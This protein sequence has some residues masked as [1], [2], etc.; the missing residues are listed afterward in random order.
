MPKATVVTLPDPSRGLMMPNMPPVTQKKAAKLQ[1]VIWSGYGYR[2]WDV[3]VSLVDRKNLS[4]N[5]LAF[6]LGRVAIMGEMA[7]FGLAFFAAVAELSKERALAVG[8]WA[9]AG[10]VSG[11]HYAE[12]GV[13]I[14]SMLAYWR[15][16][17]K[18]TRMHHKLLAVPLL[19]FAT[20]S[21]GG[22]VL[23]LCREATL[24]NAMT[25][26]FDAA[27]CMVLAYIFMY[28]APLLA[29]SR[30]G[31]RQASSENWMCIAVLLALAVAGIGSLTIYGFNIRN[32]AGS[33]LIMILALSGGAGLGAAVGVAIG[34]V[35]GLTEG[36]APQAITFYALSG[37]LAG[38]FRPLGKY[39]VILGYMLGSVITALYFGQ[40]REVTVVL[41]E[42][43]FAAAVFL[44]L[45]A[46]RLTVWSSSMMQVGADNIQRENEV[47]GK[48]NNIKDMFSDLANTFADIS[49]GAEERIREEELTRVLS[50]VGKKVCEECT[51]RNGCWENDFYQTSQGL[52]EMLELAEIAKLTTGNMPRHFRENCVKRADLVN[53][54]NLVV[55]RNHN[56]TYW[57]KKIVG[58]RQT[59][60]EQMQATANI[61]D[62]LAHEITKEPCSDKEM[63]FSIKEKAALLNCRLDSVRV[64]GTQGAA[65]VDICKQA[66]NGTRECTNTILPMVAN[67]MHEKL[68]L[69]AECGGGLK[70]KKCK[71]TLQT[72]NRFGVQTGMASSPKESHGVCGDTCAVVRL[73]K[74]KVALLLSDGMGSG[75]AAAAE[76]SMAVR[77]IEKLLSAGFDVDVAVKTINSM[78]LL[79]APDENFATVD[80]AIIDTYSGEVEFLKIGSA[81]SF[82]KRVREVSSIKSTSLPIGILS[83]IEIEP[84]KSQ[85]VPGDIIVM[86]SDGIVDA[87]RGGMEKEEWLENFL[88]RIPGN[89]P[90][91]I[92]DHVLQ[93]AVEMAGGRLRDDM[94]VLV[95]R[96]VERPEY[97]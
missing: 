63:A 80:M 18:L 64:T 91:Q 65:T 81:P 71:V 56:L 86:V 31:V 92:A 22:L 23:A 2:I 32:M 47:V 70:Q 66:C 90:Q 6:L 45:P 94:M 85:V 21:L 60:A 10:V 53:T 62:S 54:V 50:A 24:Y 78:L 5:I 69:R 79:K 76:S 75:S 51:R 41:A 14:F 19:M 49:D 84:I 73:N 55:E 42:A 35:V 15:L 68:T 12:A 37:V 96:I 13:Y 61:I 16:A 97:T 89:H 28:S 83:H 43:A 1:N 25:A 52:L 30:A 87:P 8:F 95:A 74:G 46:E 88:R 36:S 26:I 59:V 29:G 48:L 9:A 93:K 17:G 4:L 44:M 11:G 67:L 27:L 3:L 58:Q 38:V 7:P 20:V 77:F 33:M 82:I 72:A 57:Q 40:V 39:A 34:L